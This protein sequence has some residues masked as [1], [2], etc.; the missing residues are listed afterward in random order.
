M[1]IILTLLI[2]CCLFS[3][4]KKKVIKAP[5]NAVCS[6]KPPTNEA[7]AAAFSR[8]FYNSGSNSCQLINY[9]GCSQVGFATKAECDAC[10]AK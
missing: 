2:A 8:W 10:S 6:E 5:A 3:C 7:C 4:S 1:K 9:S